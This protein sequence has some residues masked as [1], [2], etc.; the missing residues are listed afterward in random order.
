[1]CAE[2]KILGGKV[3]IL[4]IFRSEDLPAD[5]IKDRQGRNRQENKMIEAW[6]AR[7]EDIGLSP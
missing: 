7:A 6:P 4:L 5:T 2:L 3:L 1:M